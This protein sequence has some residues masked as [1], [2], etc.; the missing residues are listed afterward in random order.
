MSVFERAPGVAGGAPSI[1]I[2]GLTQ[3]FGPVRALD[4]VSLDI[5]PGE[6]VC[7]LGHSGCGK[8]T[9]L[10][11]VA[12][13]QEPD[14]GSIVIGGIEVAGPRR[15][16]E[17]ERRG[18]GLMVQDYA[19]FPHLSVLD[20]VAFGLARPSSREARAGALAALDRVGMRPFA[21]RF[22][23]MLSGGEQQRVALARALAPGPK[24]LLLDE[25]FSNLDRR[26]A[27]RVRHETIGLLEGAQATV[28]IVTHDPEEAMHLADRIVLMEGGRIVQVGSPEDL[29]RRPAT[30]FAARF[31]GE[32]NE[33][34]GVCREGSIETALGRFDAP[35]LEEGTSVVVCFRPQA[36]Q[37]RAQG[38]PARILRRTFL[39]DRS[40]LWL[41]TEDGQH[42]E[43]S[44]TDT[45]S[46]EP[47]S[48]MALSVDPLDVFSFPRQSAASEPDAPQAKLDAFSLEQI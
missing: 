22:P 48:W 28:I 29:Y 42:V 26:T 18:V 8:S 39:G 41:A 6:I 20:N 44:V 21:S 43:V 34:D 1:G 10:R 17:P 3:N 19:L 12:G 24:V 11:L 33:L 27:V 32:L 2:T 13:L 25:P 46:G 30:L 45:R 4:D 23:H 36:V 15:F 31:F 38:V 35:G 9:L 16:V 5:A 40:L 14:A 47:G 37:Q 7:L